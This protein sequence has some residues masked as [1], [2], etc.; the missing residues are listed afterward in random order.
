MAKLYRV[1]EFAERI[2]KSTSTLRRWDRE[3]KLP[4]KRSVGGHRYYDESDVRKALGLEKPDVKKKTVVYCRVSSQGQL[5]DLKSQVS[6]MRQFCLGAGIAVDE[7]I[8]EVGGGMNFK[9]KKFLSIFDR[10]E[11][12]EIS[13]LIVAH[14]D[15]LVRFGFDFFEIFA[16]KHGCEMVIVNQE[17]L[18]PQ[19]EMVE[20]LMAIVHCFSSRL[21]GLRNYKKK[22]REVIETSDG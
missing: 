4:A 21:Y 9:R 18:S 13:K 11:Q 10:I 20:D 12:G 15:R 16:Q 17:Q 1:K 5:P 14:K 6:A 3:V 19:Q 8:E 2:G 22:I 7:W